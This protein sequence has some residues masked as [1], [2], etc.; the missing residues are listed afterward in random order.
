M[1]PELHKSLIELG[2]V[3][4]VQIDGSRVS[5][6]VALT[7]MGWARWRVSAGWRSS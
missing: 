5:I 3:R 6:T 1:D 4:R 7:T 2:M